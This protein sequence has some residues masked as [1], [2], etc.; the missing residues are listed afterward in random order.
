M[1]YNNKIT[2]QTNY[3]TTCIYLFHLFILSSFFYSGNVLAHAFYP[4]NGD[5][6]YDDDETWTSGSTSGI[7]FLAVAT[8]EFGHSLGLDHSNI[9]TAIMAPFYNGY[10]KNLKLDKDDI[11]AIQ[12]WYGK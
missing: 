4:E 9:D 5:A 6:H 1:L 7:N 8:H 3:H 10:Q 11:E 12:K 2:K